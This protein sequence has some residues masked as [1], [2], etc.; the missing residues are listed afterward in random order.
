MI[1]DQGRFI[2]KQ[3]TRDG[4]KEL[5]GR[6]QAEVALR[7]AVKELSEWCDVTKFEFTEY[8]K[9]DRITPLIKEWKD[10]MTEV[11]DNLDLLSSIKESKH[12]DTFKNKID[13]FDRK[14]GGLEE[15]LH[16]LNIIQ[17]KWVYLEPIFSRGTL[18][19][20]NKDRFT[21]LDKE[22]NRIMNYLFR[23]PRITNLNSV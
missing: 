14:M 10:L 20:E 22:F 16:K 4:I 9:N 3:K 2:Q 12:A 8:K 5:N 18:S 17:R 6:V 11:S 21:K 23:H 13:F 7:E 19:Q 15:Y 1:L